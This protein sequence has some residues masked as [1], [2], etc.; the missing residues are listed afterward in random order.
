MTG[1]DRYQ[2]LRQQIVQLEK[3]KTALLQ[4]KRYLEGM[5]RNIE[6]ELEKHRL[7][8]NDQSHANNPSNF[9]DS[10]SPT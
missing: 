2:F 1:T 9:N 3:E 7:R 8:G 10:S 6:F 4:M 5:K